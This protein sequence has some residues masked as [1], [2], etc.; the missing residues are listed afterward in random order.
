MRQYTLKLS[1]LLLISS[2]LISDAYNGL[3]L[4]SN[5]QG[6]GPSNTY[7]INNSF[8]NV[9]VWNHSIGAI[10]IPHLN[11]DRTIIQQFRSNE[12]YFGNT[13]IS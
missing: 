4:Y 2:F 8:N 9:N 7:V 3:I 6:V 11:P 13:S 12:H 1:C 10:G 5:S